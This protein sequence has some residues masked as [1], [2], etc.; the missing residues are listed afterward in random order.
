MGQPG[1]LGNRNLEKD[2]GLW[3]VL[4]GM[5]PG[6]R[7][8]RESKGIWGML[9]GMGKEFKTVSGTQ[10]R[11]AKNP[12]N[13]LNKAK[14]VAVGAEDAA[15]AGAG[16]GAVN[17]PAHSAIPGLNGIPTTGAMPANV[18]AGAEGAAEAGAKAD[19]WGPWGDKLLWGGG[20]AAAGWLGNSMLNSKPPQQEY[21]P[22]QG[23]GY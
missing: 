19:A 11:W 23:Y 3:S 7:D 9:K 6:L 21:G 1:V 10:A 2:A 18:A 13:P 20:G 16:A 15:A 12:M 17:A 14:N 5:G 22:P 4:K 8:L